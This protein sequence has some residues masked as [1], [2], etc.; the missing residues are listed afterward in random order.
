MPQLPHPDALETGE[1]VDAYLAHQRQ[2]GWSSHQ[3]HRE[4]KYLGRA[5]AVQWNAPDLATH[6]AV[7]RFAVWF[8]SHEP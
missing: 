2:T 4:A 6:E 3:L 5:A 7:Q 1:L 8:K